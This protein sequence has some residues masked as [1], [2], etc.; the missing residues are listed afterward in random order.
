MEIME[1]DISAVI[2][3]LLNQVLSN[4]HIINLNFNAFISQ[5]LLRIK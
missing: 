4:T 5:H 1:C 3:S 2:I